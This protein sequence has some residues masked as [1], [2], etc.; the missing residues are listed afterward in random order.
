MV[1][2]IKIARTTS[3]LSKLKIPYISHTCFQEGFL[4][5]YNTIVQ[6]SSGDLWKM[7]LQLKNHQKLSLY[8]NS[9]GAIGDYSRPLVD[10]YCRVWST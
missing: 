4:V 2:K 10:R 3:M 5:E 7:G 9:F 6:I 1:L 8:F